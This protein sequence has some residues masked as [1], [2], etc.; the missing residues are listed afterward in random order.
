MKER[1][2]CGY[3]GEGKKNNIGQK[4]ERVLDVFQGRAGMVATGKVDPGVR[5][6]GRIDI[7]D[8]ENGRTQQV[9]RNSQ[10]EGK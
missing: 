5:S 7:K 1:A 6:M 4:K 2:V 9:R 10:P 3:F 8:G